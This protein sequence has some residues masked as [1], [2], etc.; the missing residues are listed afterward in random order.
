MCRSID[1]EFGPLGFNSPIYVRRIGEH[2]PLWMPL[3]PHLIDQT[4]ESSDTLHRV[5]YCVGRLVAAGEWVPY[6]G[7]KGIPLTG[8]SL[9][10]DFQRRSTQP[11]TIH[12][13]LRRPRNHN[14]QDEWS[15]S[16]GYHLLSLMAHPLV[17]DPIGGALARH[18][19]DRTKNKSMRRIG[20][21][22]RHTP[23]N[24]A[25]NG[26]ESQDGANAGVPGAQ[27]DVLVVYFH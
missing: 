22:Y 15:V 5:F 23:S 10:S 3:E 25:S 18:Y 13:L 11:V 14:R 17:C 21:A 9:S 8:T 16:E 4:G 7:D 24:G 12:L 27:D 20:I 26:R 2:V 6:L 1:A 19:S